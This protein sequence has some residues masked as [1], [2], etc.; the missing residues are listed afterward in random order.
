MKNNSAFSIIRYLSKQKLPKRMLRLRK[1]NNKD[2]E[3][4][5]G[6]EE[7]ST[8]SDDEVT[9]DT[10]LKR[11]LERIRNCPFEV[12]ELQ[13]QSFGIVHIFQNCITLEMLRLA[14][15]HLSAYLLFTIC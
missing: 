7:G 8:D 12:E 9:R 6:E 10:E 2:N 14:Y 1:S 11:T 13:V 15:K 3:C 5:N 4:A